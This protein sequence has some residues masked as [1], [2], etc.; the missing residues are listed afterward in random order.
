MS[1]ITP[2][3]AQGHIMFFVVTGAG[4][5]VQ[6]FTAAL[7]PLSGEGPY[8]ADEAYRIDPAATQSV[9]AWGYFFNVTPGEYSL[10]FTVPQIH[11]CLT[12]PLIGFP[13][14]YGYPTSDLQ[15][16]RVPVL[17]GRTTVPVGIYCP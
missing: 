5:Y 1:G 9:G 10:R 7:T 8:F 6:G 4:S 3:P 12:W 17:P 15:T 16:I 11:G 2:D 13:D 14:A